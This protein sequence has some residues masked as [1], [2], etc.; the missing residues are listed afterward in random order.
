MRRQVIQHDVDFPRP[1]HLACQ[2]REKS[3]KFD[4]GV[5]ARRLA[6]AAWQRYFNL[7]EQIF[8]GMLLRSPT[9]IGL[10]GR[11]DLRA[12]QLWLERHVII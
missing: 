6:A 11:S 9:L 1:F 4:A 5:G 7:R 12:V 10:N 8:A 2:F 3:D